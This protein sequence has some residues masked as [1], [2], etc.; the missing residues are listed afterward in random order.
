MKSSRRKIEEALW[1]CGLHRLGRAL[2]AALHPQEIQRR[3]KVSAFY[4]ALLQPNGLV[5][6]VGA[7]VGI[8][9]ALFASLGHRVIAVEPNRDCVRHIELSYP[10]LPITVVNAVIGPKAGLAMMHVSDE[11]DDISS[12]REDWIPHTVP[13]HTVPV[14]MLSLNDLIAQYGLPAF[15]KID[16]EGFEESVLDGLRVF[17]KLLSFEFNTGDLEATFRCLAKEQ[18]Q[19]AVFNY[20]LADPQRFELPS[21]VELD[22]LKKDLAALA[23]G[24]IHSAQRVYGDVFAKVR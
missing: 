19:G 23:R 24:D 21:W 3:Q 17:P 2:Y 22:V 1:V 7:N 15:I 13:S 9:S 18:F 16:V 6:D 12:M 5:F 14:P 10:D 4:A 20:A 11:R 8:M